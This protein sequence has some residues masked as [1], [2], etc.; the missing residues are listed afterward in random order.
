MLEGYRLP[1]T[2]PL[3]D[4]REDLLMPQLGVLRLEDPVILVGEAQ[5]SA[6]HALALERGERRDALGLDDAVVE[7]AVDDERRSL[8]VLHVVDRVVLDVA[9]ALLPRHA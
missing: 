5:E 8:P 4:P 1:A 9:L 3:V 2:G 7:A 6:R